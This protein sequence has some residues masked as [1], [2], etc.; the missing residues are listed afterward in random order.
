MQVFSLTS[1]NDAILL[2]KNKIEQK[3]EDTLSKLGAFDDLAIYG[4]GEYGR[5]IYEMLCKIGLGHKVKFFVSS[6]VNPDN[7]CVCD[8]NVL[9]P[10]QAISQNETLPVFIVASMF[11]AEIVNHL[12]NIIPSCVVYRFSSHDHYLF[13]LYLECRRENINPNALCFNLSWIDKFNIMNLDE[14]L[15]KEIEFVLSNLKDNL[16]KKILTARCNSILSGDIS[17]LDQI[18]IYQNQYFSNEYYH[19]NENE[20]FFD[21]GAYSGDSIGSFLSFTNGNYK[22]ILAFEP[23]SLA[24][25]RLREFIQKNRYKAIKVF[26]CCLGET[27]R[28][29]NF[30]STN[31]GSSFEVNPLDLD[32]K[33]DFETVKVKKLDDFYD[34]YPTFIKMDIEGGELGALKGAERIIRDLHPKLAVCIYHKY[35]DFYEIPLLIK[36]FCPDYKFKIRQHYALYGEVVLYASVED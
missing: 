26:D 21:C 14:T 10:E 22:K 5:I 4:T 34:E 13:S 23:D 19:I 7:S 3:L 30:I 17:L 35:N 1:S 15:N 24:R 6:K 18:P 29:A 20:V 2:F 25:G 31:T 16:S 33:T 12:H 27:N 36:K 11:S 32:S 8:K 9:T 28:T